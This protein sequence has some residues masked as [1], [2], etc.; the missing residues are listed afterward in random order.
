MPTGV[1]T[2]ISTLVHLNYQMLKS[3]AFHFLGHMQQ[4]CPK[5]KSL[6]VLTGKFI[7][8]TNTQRTLWQKGGGNKDPICG[9]FGTPM[10]WA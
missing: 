5:Q 4:H 1:G 3:N 8:R 6:K 9:M 10:K 2:K 7:I